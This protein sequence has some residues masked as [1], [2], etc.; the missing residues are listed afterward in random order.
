MRNFIFWVSFISLIS[1]FSTA[2]LNA[3]ASNTVS[4]NPMFGVPLFNFPDGETLGFMT[5]G[6]KNRKSGRFDKMSISFSDGNQTNIDNVLFLKSMYGE[7]DLVFEYEQDGFLKMYSLHQEI[8]LRKIDLDNLSVAYTSL[9]DFLVNDFTKGSILYSGNSSLPLRSG[10]GEGFRKIIDIHG[11]DLKLEYLGL[12]TGNWIKVK[13]FKYKDRYCGDPSQEVE[14][15]IDGWVP[16]FN[17]NE[18]LLFN[19]IHSPCND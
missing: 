12:Q 1:F 10:A 5:L 13:L 4:Q 16:L 8:W 19:F 9:N 11:D 6:K 18:D 3:D 2:N 14:F 17:K 7:I 15:S